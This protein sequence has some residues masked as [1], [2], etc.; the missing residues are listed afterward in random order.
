MSRHVRIAIGSL[1]VLAGCYLAL[2]PQ[3]VAEQMQKVP[4]TPS[5][6]INLR[7]SPG[8]ALIG[9]GAFV[10]W[11]PA[12]KPWSQTVLGFLGWFMAGILVARLYGF[13]VDGSPD[14]RQWLWLWCEIGLAL[15]C[16]FAIRWLRHRTSSRA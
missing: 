15:G 5:D 14:N 11:L 12:V 3:L 13:I 7:A 1:L 10:A 8:G 2:S 6:V 16:F 9:I 4:V